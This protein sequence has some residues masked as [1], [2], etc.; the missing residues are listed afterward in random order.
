MTRSASVRPVTDTPAKLP[1]SRPPAA[2]R[3]RPPNPKISTDGTRA[4]S[5]SARLAA[6]RSPDG[7]PHEIITRIRTLPRRGEQGRKDRRVERHAGQRA[8]QHWSAGTH[9]LRLER[10]A[11]A[12]D[13]PIVGE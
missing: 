5:A 6:Y 4:R 12:V 1:T 3:R 7:S 2:S 8:R 11:D 9:Q 10:H 13:R